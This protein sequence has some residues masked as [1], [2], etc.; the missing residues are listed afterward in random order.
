MEIIA[1]AKINL[2]LD[3]V[4]KREDGYHEMNMIMVPLALHDVLHIEL[5]KQDE[6][7]CEQAMPMDDSNT[8]IKA[9]YVLREEFKFSQCFRVH[10]EKHIPMQAGMAGGS[11]D[12]AATMRGIWKL[13]QLPC[14]LEQLSLLGKRIG[15]DV[16]FCVMNT[17]SMVS[18]IGEVVEPFVL[19][20]K[21]HVLLVK[22]KEGVSTKDAFQKLDFSTCE[23][24][25]TQGCKT[26]LMESDEKA[27]YKLSGNTLEQSALVLVPQILKIKDE[28]KHLGVDFVLMSGSGSTVF[29]LSRNYDQIHNA[30]CLLKDTYPFVEMSETI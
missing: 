19:P 21:F 6:L 18:G 2:C 12:A 11:A 16:P 17:C 23:H 28:I 13:L 4:K 29:A 1:N 5:S 15:A 30:Y 25:D 3:V 8:I 10:V 7:I 9:I 24:P 20:F 22:P 26:S 14:T 27:F